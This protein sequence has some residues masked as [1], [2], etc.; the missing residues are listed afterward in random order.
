MSILIVK[1][2]IG[3][4]LRR[5]FNPSVARALMVTGLLFGAV[6]A[7][8]LASPVAT[9]TSL[10]VL[11]AG[12]PT[13]TV[14]AGT[15]VVLQ[16]SVT[17]SG[18][19]LAAGTVRFCEASAS[20]CTGV[21]LLGTVPVTAQ[22]T[23]TLRFRPGAGNH[24]F[25][26][27]FS[28]MATAAAS[29][30]NTV[31]LTVTQTQVQATSTTLAGS[32]SAGNYT[33]QATVSAADI[34]GSAA[35]LSGQ[36]ISFLDQTNGNTVLGTA[37]LSQASLTATWAE[38]SLTPGSESEG[39]I[40][41]D[42]N[43]DGILDIAI[44]NSQLNEVDPSA[45]PNGT[46]SIYLGKG[47]GTFT[48]A[49]QSP[50]TVGLD[51]RSLGAID[52]N[53]DGIPDLVVLNSYSQN[54]YVLLGNGDGTFKAA[55]G[56]PFK[57]GGN[58]TPYSVA[59]AD[60]NGDGKMDMATSGWGGQTTNTGAFSVLLGN[61]DGTFQP[62]LLVP[63]G[64]IGLI[65]PSIVTGDFNGDGIPDLA[66]A[67]LLDDEVSIM[68][69]NG[70]GT[71]HEAASSPVPVAIGSE[72]YGLI[73]TDF[74]G[75]GL[76]DLAT[77]NIGDGSVTVLLGTAAGDGSFTRVDSTN[78]GGNDFR[79]SD[80]IGT[81]D[82]NGDGIPDIVLA[83]DNADTAVYFG[84]GDG[85]FNK[86]T[87]TAGDPGRNPASIAVGDL[88]GD[89]IDDVVVVNDLNNTISNAAILITHP[90]MQ[91]AV[92]VNNISPVGHGDHNVVAQFA[93]AGPLNASTSNVII[94]IASPGAPSI[95]LTPSATSILTTDKLTATVNV[96]GGPSNP[97][98]SGSLKLLSGTY[99][100]AN[101]PLT[102]GSATITIPGESLAA[103]TDVI[104]ATYTPDAAGAT[105]YVTATS[106]SGPITVTKATPTMSVS[107]ASTSIHTVDTLVVT[108]NVTSTPSPTGTVTLTSG[109]YTSAATALAQGSATVTIPAGS[110]AVGSDTIAAAYAPDAAS[111]PV[112]NTA[113]AT[114]AAVTVSKVTPALTLNVSATVITDQ[115]PLTVNV[116]AGTSGQL[117]PT[118]SV[119]ITSGS[120]SAQA[121]L[122]SGV[123]SVSVPAGALASGA[124]TLTVAYSGD[125]VY[126]TTAATTSV[127]VA[128]LAMSPTSPSG[129]SAGGTGT[130]TLTVDAGSTYKGTLN[131][132]CA[133]TSSPTGAQNLPT[134]TLNPAS[135][136]FAAPGSATATLTVGT[137]GT[138]AALRQDERS[139]WLPAGGVTLALLVMMG[140]PR[141]RRRSTWLVMLFLVI[142]AGAVGCGG[143]GGS[144][145]TQP[146]NPGTTAGTYVFTVNAVDSVVA[147]TTTSTTV[148]F[149]VN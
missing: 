9:N 30:S 136:T 98:P 1:S 81:G 42:L 40:V 137:T 66:V 121:T 14:T 29:T 126:N 123:A 52:L 71:F 41:A 140:I 147:T 124:D 114:S 133:L 92:T 25:K 88:N 125:L 28:G 111:A 117:S 83:G 105:T 89:G 2:G 139:P 26:A 20:F 86:A 35:A 64:Q 132:T 22:G 142:G 104:A 70:D 97:T 11:S 141:L 51:T 23:A 4:Y 82:L 131:L 73:T 149:T 69:G 113:T 45:S 79:A 47:D 96:T 65:A 100:S 72:P 7:T 34:P 75:D 15:V 112:F 63:L 84:V 128:S 38:S 76:P 119:T 148:S 36:T 80:V 16:A 67:R 57:P 122:A 103:G 12:V 31:S 102:G 17:Q 19:V 56:S 43:G 18:T 13:T 68:L 130:A 108:V 5:V 8:A 110:L 143:G 101:T 145:S 62:P 77:M 87:G 107:T 135:L 109:A 120:Y 127:T 118:G 115:Q 94:L 85:T 37:P 74:N 134:C 78:L 46:V 39:V 50:I 93:A 146:V 54:I 90:V 10:Q 33:L 144:T 91:A 21:N 55:A 116:T 95:T 53:G 61:G 49:P 138:S 32:G 106:N 44:A 24:E 48:Q 99:A 6:A 27:V 3:A 58:V 59:F 60:F 129:I